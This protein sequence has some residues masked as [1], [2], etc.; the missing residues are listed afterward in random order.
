[1]D[2]VIT[3]VD[4]RDPQW[5]AQYASFV[6]E[7]ALTKRFRDWGTLRYIFRGI[8]K[9]IPF[10]SKVHLVVASDSQVP[11]W[12]NRDTVNVVLHSDIIPERFLPVFNSTA[13]EMYLHHI[14]GLD[15]EFVYFNDDIFPLMEVSKNQFFENGK[16]VASPSLQL[17]APNMYK[18]HARNSSNLSR[19]AAGLRPSLFFIRPQHSCSPML[20]SSSFK[21]EELCGDEIPAS[22]TRL[23]ADNNLCQ[24]VFT[25]YMYYTGKLVRRRMSCKHFSLA[26]SSAA[27]IARYIASPDRTF[28][29]IND[30]SLQE[31][32]FLS[33]R[34][35]LLSAFEE[36]FPSVSRYEAI[37]R[38]TFSEKE[39]PSEQ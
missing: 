11:D 7:E 8:E 18:K 19:K 33:Y 13:I 24:Y 12:V 39:L 2:I 6:G 27:K 37:S 28:A 15:E 21:L 25:D 29:C 3:Y 10:V 17:L 16:A 20:K 30:V 34:E 32:T 26:T 23:R 1:M 5:E 9:Y 4:G 14:P 38:T 22:V 36:K 35:T 31:E